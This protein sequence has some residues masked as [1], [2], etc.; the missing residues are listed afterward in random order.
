MSIMDYY[1]TKRIIRQSS[2]AG[3]KKIKIQLVETLEMFGDGEEDETIYLI[4]IEGEN[5]LDLPLC[6]G[7][8]LELFEVVYCTL[9]DNIADYVDLKK[10]AKVGDR[11]AIMVN[12]AKLD[13]SLDKD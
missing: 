13:S 9:R 3:E 5:G 12:L 2:I 7:Y 4:K 10:F 11:F 1:E 6:E 8:D